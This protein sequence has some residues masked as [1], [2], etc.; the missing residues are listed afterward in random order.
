MLVQLKYKNDV[1]PGYFISDEGKIYDAEGVEQELKI[2]S[3]KPYYFF[4]GQRVHIMMAH[5]FLGYKE[6]FVVHHKNEI[7][8]DN[9]LQNLSYMSHSDH[10]I[11]H[12]LGKKY[13]LGKKHTE[14]AKSKII[15]GQKKKQVYC[16]QLD[17]IFAGIHIAARELS[18]HQSSISQCCKGKY[19]TTGGYHF[20]FVNV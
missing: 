8:Y 15:A 12:T 10:T 4:K 16:V 2:Y 1:I 3:S 5:S 20:Q 17:R 13:H 11:L 6:G 9:R 19:K 14:Q 18:L 7:K